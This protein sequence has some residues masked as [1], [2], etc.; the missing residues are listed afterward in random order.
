V[1]TPELM[2]PQPQPEVTLVI[3]SCGRFDL[4]QRSLDSFFKFNTYPLAE[5]ILKED[6]DQPVPKEL[7]KYHE[8]LTVVDDEAGEGQVRSI[9]RAYDLVSTPYVFHMEDDWEFYRAG[10][11]EESLAILEA[12]PQCINVWLRERTDTNGHP[13]Y[14]DRMSTD[15]RGWHGF[16]WNPTLKRM[17]DY[18]AVGS[19]ES[20]VA[21][22]PEY[23]P[24]DKPW[25]KEAVVGTEYWRRGFYAR[26]TPRGYVR[27]IGENRRVAK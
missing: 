11:I 8:F 12:E 21:A 19:Y 18:H 16:T 1:S 17:T 6:S 4:L 5:V 2:E 24:P 27:H 26:I 23:L 9:D 22:C 7:T 15:W 25:L 13:V 3:T 20:V 10:F 14:E